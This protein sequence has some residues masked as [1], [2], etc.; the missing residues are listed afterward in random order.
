MAAAWLPVIIPTLEYVANMVTSW[1]H[2]SQ[3][4]SVCGYQR[5]FLLSE[6]GSLVPSDYS[7]LWTM[8]PLVTDQTSVCSSGYLSPGPR[9]YSPVKIGCK[10]LSLLL[11]HRDSLIPEIIF[12]VD[13]LGQLGLWLP[14]VFSYWTTWAVGSLV[15]RVYPSFPSP[16]TTVHTDPGMFISY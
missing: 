1:G 8:W 16:H 11:N 2:P 12:L 13:H 3:W 7:S 15:Y 10:W 9:G 5:L 6:V 4:W 14:L